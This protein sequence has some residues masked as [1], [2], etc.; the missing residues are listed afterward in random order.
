MAFADRL[1]LIKKIEELRKSKVICFLTSV[2]PNLNAQITE[3]VVRVFFDHMLLLP[4]RPV[5]KIDVF[6]CSNGGSGTVPW[7]LVALFREYTKNLGV[8]IPY[9]CYSAATLLALGA[10]EIVMHPFAEM[11]P[12][13]P[14]VSNAFNP[15]HPQ[16]NQVLGIGVED[17][18]AYI[19]FI[20]STVGIHHEDE[21]VKTIEI[22]AQKVH[23]L[24]LG[25]VERF[26]SQSR[27]IAG[28]ILLTHMKADAD[29]HTIDEIIDNL[30]SKL[31]FHGHPINRKEARDELK[32][33]V[34]E[35]PSPELETAIW[36]LY[37]DFEKEFENRIP[38][39]PLGA[40]LNSAPAPTPTN[41]QD[42]KACI[43]LPGVSVEMELIISMVESVSLSS[44]FRQKMR[45]VVAGNGNNLEPLIRSETL[46]QE[47]LTTQAP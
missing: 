27:L 18:K 2:R 10:N 19:S 16:T 40:V 1:P 20:K 38:F 39:D 22:L 30:A 46:V 33:N 9:R 7:R 17:V 26:I 28:K 23:P 13:D 11:G 12:I 6:I 24:A 5:Q 41:P 36:N 21:L 37:E 35:N 47:W 4:E 45:Y 31:Y 43:V 8:L 15:V 3:D 14:T 32:L 25:N 42:P 34:L 44:Q 29:Q